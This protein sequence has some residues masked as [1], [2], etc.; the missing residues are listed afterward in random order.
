[1]ILRIGGRGTRRMATRSA[2]GRTV[3]ALEPAGLSVPGWSC[4]PENPGQSTLVIDGHV[5]TAGRLTEVI[6]AIDVVTPA[7]L[8]HVRADDREFVAAEM[9]AFLRVW[10]AT[11]D[12]PVTAVAPGGLAGETGWPLLLPGERRD[13]EPLVLL[14]GLPEEEPLAAVHYALRADGVR[15]AVVDQRRTLSTRLDG[16]AGRGSDSPLLRMPAGT[17]RLADVSAAYPRPYPSLPVIPDAYP[18]HGVAHRHVARLEY[19]LWR[20]L[21]T[22]RAT[23]VNRPQA[24]ASNDAKP[25]QTRAASACG[26]RVPDSLLTN[27]T[28]AA[29]AFAARHGQVIYKGASGT[30][31]RPGLLDPTDRSR[32]SRLGTCPVYF[33][34]YI[35]GTNVRV[36][37]VGTDIFPVQITS[38]ALDYR[39]RFQDMRPV[40]LP[41]AVAA[42]CAT[43]TQR[44]GLL[45]AGLDLIRTPEDEWYFLEANPSP[46]FTFFP[47][48][49][50]VAAAIAR[51]LTGRARSET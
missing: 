50:R 23:V 10:L 42:R 16:P 2:G 11:L 47:D 49:D 22:A 26:F 28:A 19:H 17:I 4:D 31:T 24:A 44:L 6:T 1:V 51:L 18:A 35:K 21:A 43:V 41:A 45:L 33:Q 29:L 25:L 38:D 14:W 9:T 8:P 34:R 48:S 27:D 46:A 36:H 30:R 32:L 12:C 39:T 3:T 40:S 15:T 37:V 20:W 5:V 7:D 13:G